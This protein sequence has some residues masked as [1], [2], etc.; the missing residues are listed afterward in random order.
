MATVG[1][2]LDV[3]VALLSSS[4]AIPAPP[5]DVWSNRFRGACR[6]PHEAGRMPRGL[7]SVSRNPLKAL[8]HPRPTHVIPHVVSPDAA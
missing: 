6:V 2:R 8:I 7:T 5:D 3:A 4:V 1:G